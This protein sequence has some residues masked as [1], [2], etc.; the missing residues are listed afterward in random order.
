[1][2]LVIIGGSDAGIAAALRARQLA[3]EVD[4]VVLVADRFPNYSICGLPYLIS[5]EVR[6]ARDLAH[7]TRADLERTGM[8]LAL[9]HEATGIDPVAREVQL[10]TLAGAARELRYDRLVVA[11]GAEP[12][13]PPLQGLDTPGVHALHTMDHALALQDALNESQIRSAIIVGAGYIGL[14][15]AEALV[16]REI[17][18]TLVEQ[19]PE[20]LPTVDPPLG[21]PLRRALVSRGVDVRTG[22]TV[23]AIE[24]GAYGVRVV[25]ARGRAHEGSLV[26][27]CVGVEP[28]S[29][30]A[31]AAGAQLGARGALKVDRLMA[32]SLPAAWAAGDC[33]ETHHRLLDRP[34][35]LPLGTTAHKQGRI[36]GENAIGGRQRFA[37]SLGTQVVKV[38]DLVAARTGLRDDDARQAGFSPLTIHTAIDDHNAYFPGARQLHIGL[39]GDRETGQLLGVQIV[40]HRSSE[41]AKRIDTAATALQFSLAV[42][43]LNALDLSYAPPLGSPWD[44]LQQAAQHWRRAAGELPPC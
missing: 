6:D 39:T 38:F 28:A 23:A 13:R 29:S 5:G 31:A 33:A 44:P 11:T 15:L 43:D 16:Q 24:Q 42:D 8:Q 30:L 19:G 17:G 3:P 2:R 25:D 36:A 7:R 1:M 27:V 26:V 22:S 9:E 14:E 21:A 34:A 32:T 41:V 35:Y 40:G 20:V 4:V 12:I 37:G 10:R 18:V